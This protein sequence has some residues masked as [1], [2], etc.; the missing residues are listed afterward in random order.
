MKILRDG[1]Q[2]H[3]PHNWGLNLNLSYCEAQAVF[4]IPYIQIYHIASTTSQ[5]LFFF[6]SIKPLNLYCRL[7]L[8]HFYVSNRFSY[9]KRK[10]QLELKLE[11][12]SHY[13]KPNAAWSSE[14]VQGTGCRSHRSMIFSYKY[15]YFCDYHWKI[16][17]EV[18][19]LSLVVSLVI[20][21]RVSFLPE[22]KLCMLWP[23]FRYCHWSSSLISNAAL[24][25]GYILWK[26]KMLSHVF[27]SWNLG[28]FST[29]LGVVAVHFW[30]CY[31]TGLEMHSSL[32][33]SEILPSS[34]SAGLA[35]PLV[36]PFTRK[37]SL[38]IW[39]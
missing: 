14:S 32:S 30:V 16:Y 5:R 12:L 38:V 21:R 19:S 4:S 9:F 17:T 1:T 6:A 24:I 37:P 28:C 2:A 3:T 22:I 13:R 23:K 18:I 36:H 26:N 39:T 7:C 35:L 11:N 27:P 20:L 8:Y 34:F 25:H 33:P 15:L 31:P 10:Y 29:F